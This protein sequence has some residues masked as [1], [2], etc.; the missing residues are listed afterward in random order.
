MNYRHAFHAGNFADVV[1]HALLARLL[2]Y[3]AKKEAPFLYLDTHAGVGRYDLAGEAATRTGEAREGVGRMAEALPGEAEAL[4][5]PWR[6]ALAAERAESGGDVYPGSPALAQRLTRGGD[7]LL[8]CERHPDDARALKAAMGRDRRVKTL[9]IDGFVAL[10]ASIPPKEKRGLVLI[11]PPFE[12]PGE[13]ERM[14]RA[15]VAAWRKWPGGVYALWAPIKD[16]AETRRLGA[17]TTAA[18]VR[19]VLWIESVVGAAPGAAP[20]GGGPPLIGTAMM[21]VN[22]PWTLEAEAR[23]L[24]PALTR[25]LARGADAR[26]R[27]ETL[28]G[29]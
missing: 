3:L 10:N 5:A 25:R 7:R 26:S 21:V 27:V 8:L 11:D 19:R 16:E 1:K 17:L 29:E 13:I 28:A 6:A 15:L 9:E 4:L 23:T 18:G 20:R 12:E 2:V 22:P 14:A 24:T